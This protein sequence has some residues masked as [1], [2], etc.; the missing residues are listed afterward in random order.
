MA[1]EYLSKPETPEEA[2]KRKADPDWIHL[3]KLEREVHEFGVTDPIK[4]VLWTQYKE[5]EARTKAEERAT[6]DE[7]TG[8][9]NRG[10]FNQAVQRI[11]STG[12]GPHNDKRKFPE[13]ERR[14]FS[15]MMI[16]VDKFKHY[17]DD[18]GHD[19]GD[20]VLREVARRF[21]AALRTGDVIARFGGDELVGLFPN[22][23]AEDIQHR[24]QK[25]FAEQPI[26][27]TIDTEK[28][29]AIIEIPISAGI[30]EFKPGDEFDGA[31]K[32]ADDALYQV[33]KNGRNGITVADA[34]KNE[35][36]K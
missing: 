36:G 7:L 10:G 8:L 17:N 13:Q 22:A 15:V 26:K 35:L 16:D 20:E 18:Y 27:I 25:L 32:A 31:L 21:A 2:E 19:V 11:V 3:E 24:F 29:P 34:E 1:M 28:G 30:K 23:H 33:K 14:Y 5:H 4:G 6:I 9:P 12:H